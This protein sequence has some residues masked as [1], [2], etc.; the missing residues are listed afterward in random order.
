MP[1]LPYGSIER[2]EKS[3]IISPSDWTK[4]RESQQGAIGKCDDFLDIPPSPAHGD[5][6]AGGKGRSRHAHN[7]ATGVPTPE[8]EAGR[9]EGLLLP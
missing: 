5:H 3:A 9:G 8:V 4:A 2:M 1:F 6:V 7:I